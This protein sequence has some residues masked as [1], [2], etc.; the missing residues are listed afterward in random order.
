M[1]PADCPTWEY[2]NHPERT[3]VL[4]NEINSILIE[5]RK[6]QINTLDSVVDTRNTHHRLF[7]RLTPPECPYYAGH[8]RGENFRCL[9]YNQVVIRSDPRVGFK[10]HLVLGHLDE[11][12]KIIREA[13]AAL[14]E[15]MKVPNAKIQ[16][17]DKIVY[18][19]AATCRIFE[20]FLRI[21]PYVNGNGHAARF[22][23][24]ALLGRYG[25]WPTKW[26]IDPRPNHPYMDLIVEYR[27]GNP[28]ALETSI[29]QNLA[30]NK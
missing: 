10:P 27:N 11:L 25:L 7:N 22:C 28:V 24:W 9:K 18:I 12:G 21:H 13:V 1:H 14:D 23:V 5:L 29:M 15:G 26:P 19:V 2:D 6:Q 30:S 8:Y 4:Q 16:L 3:T 20:L 17:K